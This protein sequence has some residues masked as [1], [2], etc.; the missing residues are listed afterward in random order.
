M[1]MGDR[2][3]VMRDGLLQQVGTPRE[4]YR[5][6]AN[7]FVAGFIGS[8]AM[9]FATFELGDDGLVLGSTK[10]ALPAADLE[11]LKRSLSGS[12]VIVGFRPEHL[13]LVERDG[14]PADDCWRLGIAVDVVEY[15]GS[16]ELVHS[17]LEGH[18]ILALIESDR[19]FAVGQ[20]LDLE[21]GRAKLHFF[22]AATTNRVEIDSTADRP[23]EAALR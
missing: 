7:T 9:N 1:T 8:P 4:L 20:S 12:S 6:P 21:V 16:G 22:D 15:L 11:S 23:A 19:R 10:L 14:A 18:E 5:S 2:L 13:R 17:Q 3:A